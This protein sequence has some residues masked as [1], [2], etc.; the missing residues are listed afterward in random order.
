[1]S[2]YIIILYIVLYCIILYY[3]I[4]VMLYYIM[5]IEHRMPSTKDIFCYEENGENL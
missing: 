2:Y 3:I 1:M 5:F 4:S